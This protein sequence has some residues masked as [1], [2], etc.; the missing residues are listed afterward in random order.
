VIT[1]VATIA[2]PSATGTAQLTFTVND[3]NGQVMFTTS[4]TITL[5]SGSTDI[6]NLSYI[7]RSAL[8]GKYTFSASLAYQGQ[9][10]SKSISFTVANGTTTAGVDQDA[11]V[12]MTTANVLQFAFR[13]GSTARFMIPFANFTSSS[14]NVTIKYQLNGP[15]GSNAGTGSISYSAPTG[16]SS[17]TVD[18]VLPASTQQALYVFTSNLVIPGSFTPNQDGTAITVAPADASEQVAVDVAFVANTSGVPQG[19]FAP[20][21]SAKLYVRRFSSFALSVPVTLR[22]K[23]TAPDGA[24][25]LDQSAPITLANG[26]DTGYIPLTLSSS[27]T[28]GTYRFDATI[29]YQDNSNATKS[30]TAGATFVVGSNPPALTPAVT[31]SRLYVL[32]QNLVT[33]TTFNAN[34]TFVLIPSTYSTYTTPVSGQTQYQV[35]FPGALGVSYSTTIGSSYSPGITLG[36]ALAL[37]TSLDKTFTFVATTDVGGTFSTNTVTFTVTTPNVAAIPFYIH[38][39]AERRD[40]SM[41]YADSSG[42]FD[43]N[44]LVER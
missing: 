3:P 12:P 33:R 28:A 29:T 16:M 10:N 5:A 35:Q 30:S 43:R 27:A 21:S 32:D 11:S 8:N 25:V 20:G 39:P 9:T 18:M 31:T 14:A 38:S 17:T 13:P 24:V 1:Y 36:S 22:Y 4:T 7:P 42:S 2:N 34:E 41:R 6:P 26:P 23:V 40:R 44:D 19:G 15:G 37:Y